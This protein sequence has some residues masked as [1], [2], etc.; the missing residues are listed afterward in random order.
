LAVSSLNCSPCH[1]HGSRNKLHESAGFTVL[2]DVAATW[3]HRPQRW[4]FKMAGACCVTGGVKQL[5]NSLSSSLLLFP[6]FA[7][8]IPQLPVT[9]NWLSWLFDVR[10]SSY[11]FKSVMSNAE[12]SEF[13][14]I[15]RR[16][17]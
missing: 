8:F 13:W 3:L 7:A 12:A 16:S 10:R 17:S 6:P 4:R 2:T 9:I 15:Y 11:I 5:R 1:F 14:Q